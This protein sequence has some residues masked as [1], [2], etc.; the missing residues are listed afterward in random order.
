MA[1]II[2][3]NVPG[4]G[5]VNPSLPVVQELVNR[6]HQVIYYNTEPFRKHIEGTGAEFRPYPDPSPTPEQITAMSDNLVN[7]TIMLMGE[8]LRLLPFILNILTDEKP[9]LIMH[10]AI[11]NHS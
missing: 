7:F 6:G 5:H 8:S 9:D 3:F 4:F 10:D 1:K 11:Q 2:Y